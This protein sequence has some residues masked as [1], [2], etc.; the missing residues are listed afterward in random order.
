VAWAILTGM[1]VGQFA[2]GFH[3]LPL[4]PLSYGLLLLGPAYAMVSLSS[5]IQEKQN[6][7]WIW[8]E[9]VIMW[10]IFGVLGLVIKL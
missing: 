10:V 1:V 3:Y 7:S 8:I 2:I 6:P 5:Q 4:N 9:P